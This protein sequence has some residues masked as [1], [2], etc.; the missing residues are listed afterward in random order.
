MKKLLIC[1]TV[2]ALTLA[3]ATPTLAQTSQ[4]DQYI[5]PIE[6]PCAGLYDAELVE[7]LKQY[8]G[9]GKLT[10]ADYYN[11]EIPG[12]LPNYCGQ[13]A[14]RHIIP[15]ANNSSSQTFKGLSKALSNLK[16]G[17]SEDSE[18]VAAE[19]GKSASQP[20][21][22][23]PGVSGATAAGDGEPPLRPEEVSE[24][25]GSEDGSNADGSRKA[26]SKEDNP[27]DEGDNLNNGGEAEAEES[28]KNGGEAGTGES[29]NGTTELP[30]TGGS[31]TLLL[32]AS[33]L[34]LAGGLTM[35]RLFR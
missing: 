7:C 27:N 22:S 9:T 3:L 10:C 25:G 21:S 19:L 23:E 32:G 12:E 26:D 5:G 15:Q 28:L 6:R 31:A 18:A 30:E 2:V 33:V 13:Y 20:G 16:S 4:E 29:L 8:N 11:Y 14:G 34:L 1:T 17:G 35:F 24:S